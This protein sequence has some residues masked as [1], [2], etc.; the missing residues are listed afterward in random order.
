M[1]DQIKII[2]KNN[3]DSLEYNIGDI[4]TVDS[5]WYGGVNVTSKTGIP[6]FDDS[7]IKVGDIVKH[8]KREWVDDATSEYLYKVL[9]FASHTE[10]GEPLV[11]YQ[12]MYAPFKICARPYEMFMSKVDREKYPDVKQEYRFET[13]NS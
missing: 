7:R 2:N 6:T 13:Y 5:T 12:G 11:I 4:F 10:T 3:P 9:A 8:F 1:A